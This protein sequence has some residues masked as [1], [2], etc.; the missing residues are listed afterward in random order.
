MYR[1]GFYRGGPVLMSA[2]AGIDQAL[3]TLS[4]WGAKNKKVS[5]WL[6][7]PNSQE[8][9]PGVRHNRE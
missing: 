3:G 1:G 8:L 5:P 2:I 6:F 4:S 7:T 9:L